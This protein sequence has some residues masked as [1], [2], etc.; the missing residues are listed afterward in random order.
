MKSEF[1]DIRWNAPLEANLFDL[2]VPNGWSI[3]RTKTESAECVN[4]GFVP[5]F[6]LQIGPEGREPLLAT[7]DVAGVVR[8]E[9][10]AQPDTGM[11]REVRITIRLKPEAALRLRDYANANPDALLSPISTG[12]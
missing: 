12:R 9:Q 10:I 2:V 7:G 5:G 1:S 6:I 3:S 11:P 4:T 8:G